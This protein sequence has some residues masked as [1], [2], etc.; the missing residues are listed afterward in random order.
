[1]QGSIGIETLP[2]EYQS[3]PIS[4]A[5]ASNCHALPPG[6]GGYLFLQWLRSCPISLEVSDR[7]DA[8]EIIRQQKWTHFPGVKVCSLNEDCRAYRDDNSLRAAAKWA[9]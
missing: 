2:F 1:V 5:V 8:H 4:L 6:V 3:R 9:L 7:E